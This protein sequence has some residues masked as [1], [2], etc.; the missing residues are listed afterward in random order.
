MDN[1]LKLI[2]PNSLFM[3]SRISSDSF[4]CRLSVAAGTLVDVAVMPIRSIF[5]AIARGEAAGRWLVISIYLRRHGQ[6][7]W[8]FPNQAMARLDPQVRFQFAVN[9]VD[10]F[11]VPAERLHVAQVQVAKAETPVPLTGCQTHQ[12][13][14]DEFVFRIQLGL[15]AIAGFANAESQAGSLDAYATRL[16]VVLSHL[17]S[18]RWLH[19]FFAR[20]SATIS[21]FRRSRAYI[22]FRCQ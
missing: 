16:H 22:F 2:F 11:M 21:A 18:A 9:P 5:A 12:P 19:H 1:F 3:L 20:A 17:T 13:I 15:V 10:A 4:L 8:L 7:K 14:G 6:R